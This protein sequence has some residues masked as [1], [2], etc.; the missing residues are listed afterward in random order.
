[1]LYDV[2]I[3][4]NSFDNEIIREDFHKIYRLLNGVLLKEIDRIADLVYAICR[5]HETEGV[6]HGVQVGLRLA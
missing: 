1:M 2:Y 6:I 4:S 3:E 5:D